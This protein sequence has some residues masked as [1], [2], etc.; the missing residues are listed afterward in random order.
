MA[1]YEYSALLYLTRHA[2]DGAAATTNATT[3]ATTRD[4][5]GGAD[6]DGT[7]DVSDSAG[8][9]GGGG[10]GV[11]G[12]D[13]EG[14]RLVFHDEDADRIV[15]PEPGLLVAFTSAADTSPTAPLPPSLAP[16]AAPTAS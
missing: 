2:P 4:D 15:H 11:R 7:P 12:G 5:S 9:K 1:E 10:G 3:N 13:F 14:G 16:S 6:G 8:G